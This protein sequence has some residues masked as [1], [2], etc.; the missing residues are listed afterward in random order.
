MPSSSSSSSDNVSI[1]LPRFAIDLEE[2]P[3]SIAAFGEADGVAVAGAAEFGQAVQRVLF[4]HVVRASVNNL[5]RAPVSGEQGFDSADLVI[6]PHAA[7]HVRGHVRQVIVDSMAIVYENREE[8]TPFVLSL[9]NFDCQDLASIYKWRTEDELVC[10][11]WGSEVA[12]RLKL[13]YAELQALPNILKELLPATAE[14]AYKLDD[15][16]PGQG[17]ELRKACLDGMLDAGMVRKLYED[18]RSSTWCLTEH[19][20]QSIKVGHAA[21]RPSHAL[22]IRSEVALEDRTVWELLVLLDKEGWQHVVK[23]K[24]ND[25]PYRP[26]STPKI[27]FSKPGEDTVSFWYLLCLAQGT[28]E[29]AHWQNARLLPGFGKRQKTSCTDCAQGF[30]KHPQCG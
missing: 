13:Q 26:G 2:V 17:L 28:S 12:G 27:W 25:D 3:A 29:V 19:G 9:A 21:D 6:A 15:L 24:G 14:Q 1:S 16:V 30:A 8:K 23:D 22:E 5:V 11:L 20:V 10:G 7:L 18:E 4:F